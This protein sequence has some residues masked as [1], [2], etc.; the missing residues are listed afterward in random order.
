MHEQIFAKQ[1]IDEASRHGKV[2]GIT[3]SVG[4]LAHV[5]ADDMRNIL[6]SM[7]DWNISILNDKATVECE[8]GEIG[9]PNIVEKGHDHN[10][11]KCKSCGKLMPKILSGEEIAL[12]DITLKDE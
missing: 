6:I 11:F 1:I 8:C 3:V 7:T 10:V 5:P 12:V 2:E 4:D 9:E